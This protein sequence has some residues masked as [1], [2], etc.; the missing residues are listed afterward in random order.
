[1]EKHYIRFKDASIELK[2][3]SL[4][5]YLGVPETDIK[6]TYDENHFKVKSIE[7]E[8]FVSDYETA[9]K[10]G[11]EDFESL[12]D[13]L[14]FDVF[15]KEDRDY[16]MYKYIDLKGMWKEIVSQDGLGPSIATYDSEEHKLSNNLYAYRQD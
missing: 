1:M 12:F 14:G 2:I 6:R 4:A 11:F 7:E 9:Y 10:E 5:E 13:D 8:Y 15:R 16:W 3:K